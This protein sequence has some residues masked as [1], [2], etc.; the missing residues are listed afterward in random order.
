M[1]YITFSIYL[2]QLSVLTGQDFDSI[3]P[4]QAKEIQ[5]AIY[6][7]FV[8]TPMDSIIL[9][10]INKML[11]IKSKLESTIFSL[12]NNKYSENL[13]RVAFEKYTIDIEKNID[14]QM[15]LILNNIKKYKLYGE[16]HDSGRMYNKK[17]ILTNKSLQFLLA[18]YILDKNKL[19]SCDFFDDKRILEYQIYDLSV[20]IPFQFGYA[21]FIAFIMKDHTDK[22]KVIKKTTKDEC[23]YDNINF[24]YFIGRKVPYLKDYYK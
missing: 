22:L 21:E 16:T 17:Y 19:S 20:E 7:K 9:D 14:I 6:G 23:I 12:E 24:I 15:E 10:S 13:N 5:F 1:K 8:L 18:N 11:A 2:L 4:I 3:K